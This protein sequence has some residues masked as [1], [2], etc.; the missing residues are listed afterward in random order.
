MRSGVP[1]RVAAG[2]LVLALNDW[3]TMNL[4]EPAD[5][6]R[7]LKAEAGPSLTRDALRERSE[8][9]PLNAGAWKLE[10]LASILLISDCFDGPVDLGDIIA[11]ITSHYRP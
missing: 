3:P 8:R 7:E 10:A 2:L 5:L 1:R 11:R 9:L 4:C 6:L